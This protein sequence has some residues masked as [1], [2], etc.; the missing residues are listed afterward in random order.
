MKKFLISIFAIGSLAFLVWCGGTK[1]TDVVPTDGTTVENTTTTTTKTRDLTKDECIELVAY[2][3][4]AAQYQA[5]WDN[6]TFMVWAQ[7]T[8]DLQAKYE[9]NDAQYE[10]S[11]G[12]LMTDMT[13]MKTVQKRI[14]ELK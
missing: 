4:K 14:T 10:E 9:L 2:A 1:T 7:K 3:M 6:A 13:F 5:Q 11:C 12:M 8:A